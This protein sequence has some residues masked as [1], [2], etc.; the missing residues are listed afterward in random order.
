M[1]TPVLPMK[2][3]EKLGIIISK[4]GVNSFEIVSLSID[5]IPISESEIIKF[6]KDIKHPFTELEHRIYS[7]AA[8]RKAIKEG[9]LIDNY[10]AEKIIIDSFLLENAR[11]PHGRPIW[12]MISKNQ[13]YKFLKRI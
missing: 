10:T 12:H 3:L 1:L 6:L 2:Q 9:D 8:C 7:I 4:I 13:L 11:C 5:Y